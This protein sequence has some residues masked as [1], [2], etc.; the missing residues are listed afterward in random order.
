MKIVQIEN[1]FC[2][3]YPKTLSVIQFTVLSIFNK[4][5]KFHLLGE[6][7]KISQ[8]LLYET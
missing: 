5:L 2:N 3:S 4:I 7:R 1:N 8:N 6:T